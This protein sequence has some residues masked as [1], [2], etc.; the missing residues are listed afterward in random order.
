MSYG[1][2]PKQPK[3]DHLDRLQILHEQYSKK[4]TRCRL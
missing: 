1:K 2:K 4:G 3:K